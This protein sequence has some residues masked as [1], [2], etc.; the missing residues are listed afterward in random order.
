M[1]LLS[2]LHWRPRSIDVKHKTWFRLVLKAIGVLLLALGLPD[3]IQAGTLVVGYAYSGGYGF[4][5]F[6]PLT[7]LDVLLMTIS[8]SNLITALVKTLIGIYLLL[9][10]GLLLNLC[11]P[12]NRPYCPECGYELRGSVGVKCPECGCRLPQDLLDTYAPE[13]TPQDTNAD[14]EQPQDDDERNGLRRF[15]PIDNRPALTG[16]YL[17]VMSLI[18]CAGIIL[19]P[20]AIAF[21]MEGWRQTRIHPTATGKTHAITAI[22]LGFVTTV[23]NLIGGCA[24]A[25]SVLTS[26]T[27]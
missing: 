2:T 23:I 3:L 11:I 1:P 25:Y 17:S 10:G 4:G 20:M 19:G 26:S 9:Y 15:I 14:A 7:D 24:F 13:A 27:W 5:G 16:Y 22:V 21:G 6:G 8:S 12:S 18:P